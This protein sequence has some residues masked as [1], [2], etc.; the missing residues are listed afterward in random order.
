MYMKQNRFS[1]AYC[2]KQVHRSQTGHTIAIQKANNIDN[3]DSDS[4]TT[5]RFGWLTQFSFLNDNNAMLVLTFYLVIQEE[6]ISK[7]HNGLAIRRAGIG[8]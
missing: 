1:H 6:L 5:Q 2:F 3:P 8:S 7:I 4:R